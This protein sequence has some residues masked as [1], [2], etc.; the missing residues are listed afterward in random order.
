MT[1]SDKMR[2]V[3]D[4]TEMLENYIRMKNSWIEVP[5]E[6]EELS[7]DDMFANERYEYSIEICNKLINLLEKGL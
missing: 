6:N 7:E 1:T 2:V 5:S 3:A 4:I